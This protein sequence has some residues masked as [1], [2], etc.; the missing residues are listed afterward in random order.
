MLLSSWL[1]GCIQPSEW[2]KHH[3]LWR[4]MVLTHT[5]TYTYRHMCAHT[6]IQTTSVCVCTQKAS[7]HVHA[8]MCTLTRCTCT[9]MPVVLLPL[10]LAETPFSSWTPPSGVKSQVS[11]DSAEYQEAVRSL[12]TPSCVSVLSSSS[13]FRISDQP[14]CSVSPDP[15]PLLW[16]NP[17]VISRLQAS[18]DWEHHPGKV[19]TK[20]EARCGNPIETL[21]A[22]V[23]VQPNAHIVDTATGLSP[24]AG[25]RLGHS[26]I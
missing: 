26:G 21:V 12:P 8:H 23:A 9:H 11:K 24:T 16:Q 19:R 14:P 1:G 13:L 25:R 22:L 3:C 5:S 10:F 17:A 20:K 15:H 6:C 2:S 18:L 7:A 4:Y